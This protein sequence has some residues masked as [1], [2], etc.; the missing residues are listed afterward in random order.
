MAGLDNKCYQ[1]ASTKVIATRN[2]QSFKMSGMEPGEKIKRAREARK[3][4]QRD[5][6]ERIGVSQVAI[7][8]IE[9]GETVQSKHLPLI[10]QTLEIDLSELVPDLA[11]AGGKAQPAPTAKPFPAKVIKSR[12][13]KFYVAEWREFMGVSVN[14]AARALGLSEGQYEVL[15]FYPINLTLAQVVDLADLFG[16]RGDQLWF[17]PPKNRPAAP[18]PATKKRARSA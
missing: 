1:D 9:T 10:A 13:F 14:D 4:S 17:P 3:W 5:L 8:K 6:G 7:K 15:E 2:N 16:V 12:S 11:P 18:K